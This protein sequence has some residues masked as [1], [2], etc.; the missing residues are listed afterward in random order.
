M[1]S[2]ST[3]F[4]AAVKTAYRQ[5]AA[6]YAATWQ[7]P[8]PWMQLEREVAATWLGPGMSLIDVGCGPGR[9]A[10][11]WSGR[12]VR[13]LGVDNCPEM[14]DGARAAYPDLEFRLGDILA[15]TLADVGGVPFDGAWLAYVLLHLPEELCG[16]ALESVRRLVKPHGLVFVATTIAPTSRDKLGPIAGLRDA[17]GVEL[18]TPTHEWSLDSWARLMTSM[19]LVERWSRISDFMNGKS[20][21]LSAIYAAEP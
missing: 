6:A 1:D 8:F 21:I 7:E 17:S 12:G 2:G 4:T 11:Y 13:V 16:A 15:L 5:G 18:P 14:V 9:D 20:T 19:Q 3:S 10:R